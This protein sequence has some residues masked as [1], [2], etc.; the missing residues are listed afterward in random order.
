MCPK[1][2]DSLNSVDWV[3]NQIKQNQILWFCNTLTC[4]PIYIYSQTLKA[5]LQHVTLKIYEIE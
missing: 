5:P 4:T 2:A 1:D 3:I